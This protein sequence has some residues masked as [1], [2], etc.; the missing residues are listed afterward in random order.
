M[1]VKLLNEMMRFIEIQ[2]IIENDEF[3]KLGNYIHHGKLTRL[4]HCI[5][6]AIITFLICRQ[7]RYDFKSATRGALLHDFF[8]YDWLREGPRFHGFRHPKIAYNNARE[9]FRLNNI[10]KDSIMKHMWPL[11]PIPPKYPESLVVC[12]ADKAVTLEDYRLTIVNKMKQIKLSLEF[13]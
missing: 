2:E 4:A 3:L 7:K 11:T 10:E 6:V 9:I 13:G 5:N 8:F 1:D 12:W